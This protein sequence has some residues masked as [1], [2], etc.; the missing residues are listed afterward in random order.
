MIEKV[1]HLVLAM[2]A[3]SYTVIKSISDDWGFEATVM[4]III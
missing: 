3:Q 4:I 2:L 1:E